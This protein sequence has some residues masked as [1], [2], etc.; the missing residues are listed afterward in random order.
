MLDR[1]TFVRNIA[2]RGLHD[3]SVVIENTAAAFDAAIAQGFGIECDLQATRDHAPV[4]FHDFTCERLLSCEGPVNS[5]LLA[6]LKTKSYR[7]SA[8]RVLSFQEMLAFVD[9][10]VPILAE[11][12]SDWSPPDL[13]WL[14]TI[15]ALAEAYAG[16]LALMSFD[17]DLLAAIRQTTVH[18]PIGIVSGQYRHPDREPWYA[19][20][21]D[22]ERAKNL[23]AMTSLDTLQPDFIAYHVAD[24]EM[25]AVHHARDQLNLPVFTWTVRSADD[26]RMC[27]RFADAA[28]FEGTVPR[29]A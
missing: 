6:D 12:K 3:G 13:A 14:R 16:P 10:R 2:H 8:E 25:E 5:Y 22:A 26:W 24:L 18:L 17:P 29:R 20:K 11:L 15:C 21:I 23:S 4:V 28:I 27:R 19:D 1:S 7:N 9:G